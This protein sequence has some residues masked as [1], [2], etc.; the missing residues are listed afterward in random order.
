MPDPLISGLYAGILTS[1]LFHPID[2]IKTRS[3]VDEC[4]SSKKNGLISRCK[5][6]YKD[7][8]LKSFYRGLFP[9][10]FGAAISWGLYFS[11]YERFKTI[12]LPFADETPKIK[13]LLYFSASTGA[14]CLT[15]LITNPIWLLKTRME[16]QLSTNKQY[17][18]TFHAFRKI[19]RNE[20]MF[21]LYKGLI[22]ALIL[23]SNGAIQFM[24]YESLKE[25]LQ[26]KDYSIEKKSLS[27]FLVGVLSKSI[28]STI[29]Y[30][31]QVAKTRIQQ[32]QNIVKYKTTLQTIRLITTNE[33]FLALYKGLCPNLL[34]VAPNSA[35]TLLVYEILRNS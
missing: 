24:I 9:S 12:L 18:S 19:I 11:F 28:A 32:F 31:Y 17:S 21:G 4:N 14:G 34:R 16:L 15:V 30:P 5:L 26:L 23:T 33:G 29:T 27:Y 1:F 20:G 10:C 13:P 3:Q 8:G 35:V 22:P 6:I 25:M 7:N 2:V